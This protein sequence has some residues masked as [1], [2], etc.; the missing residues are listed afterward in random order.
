MLPPHPSYTHTHM[1]NSVG[2][3]AFYCSHLMASVM[4][5]L[6]GPHACTYHA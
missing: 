2:L 5:G 3:G 4:H 6:A 1:T